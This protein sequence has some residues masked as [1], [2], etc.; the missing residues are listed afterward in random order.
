MR[1]DDHLIYESY[2]E[3]GLKDIAAAGIMGLGALTGQPNV[4]AQQ[5]AAIEIGR[6]HV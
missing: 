5:P 3:E 6:A 2:V 1:R 4:Q